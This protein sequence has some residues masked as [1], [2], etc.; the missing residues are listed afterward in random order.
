MR[1]KTGANAMLLALFAGAGANLQAQQ[2]GGYFV[3]A[4][5][6]AG[7][8]SLNLEL[9]PVGPIHFRGGL[10]LLYIAPSVPVTGTV[11][12]GRGSSA[13]E[14]GG[15]ATFV[16]FGGRDSTHT[17]GEQFVELLVLGKGLGTITVPTGVLGYRHQQAG[18]FLFR[19]TFTPWIYHGRVLWW[20]GISIGR[21]F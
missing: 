14:I 20:G 9:A 12:I 7:L 15:G 21:T 4:G 6:N 18:G 11:V 16:F 3:E 17:F 13:L 10:G 5:G 19:A 2:R 8:V 1:V